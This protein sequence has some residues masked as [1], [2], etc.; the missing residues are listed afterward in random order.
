MG[1]EELSIHL[2]GEMLEAVHVAAAAAGAS[3]PAWVAETVEERIRRQHLRQALDAVRT[4]IGPMDDGEIARLV[5][6][7]R[8]GSRPVG[9]AGGA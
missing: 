7:A 4:E 6:E 1:R 8:R 3:V 5:A 2:D 9:P